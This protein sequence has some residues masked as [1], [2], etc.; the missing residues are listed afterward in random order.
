M[1]N[2]IALNNLVKNQAK[3]IEK[4][5][6]QIESLREAINVINARQILMDK[7][8]VSLT[9]KVRRQESDINTLNTKVK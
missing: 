5:H 7:K 3:Q 2:I 6:K 4:Q 1:N 9:E 8:R